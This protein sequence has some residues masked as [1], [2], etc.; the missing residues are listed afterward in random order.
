MSL[1]DFVSCYDLVYGKNKENDIE[2]FKERMLLNNLGKIKLRQTRA[3]LRYYLRYENEE[4]LQR[5]KLILFYPFRNEME[6]IHERDI[7]ELYNSKR[8]I[9]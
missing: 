3:I 9:I 1:A 4:E 8:E 5:A 2:H 6:Q 7:D